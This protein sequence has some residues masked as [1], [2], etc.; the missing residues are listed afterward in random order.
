MHNSKMI[1][2]AKWSLFSSTVTYYICYLMSDTKLHVI[3]Q[4]HD[5]IHDFIIVSFPGCYFSGGQVEWA[6]KTA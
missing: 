2:V 1:L 4:H 6:R 3:P 5:C